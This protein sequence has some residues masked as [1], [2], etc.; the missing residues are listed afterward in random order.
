MAYD[1][2]VRQV[3][4]GNS[5]DSSLQQ[6]CIG[7]SYNSSLQ[8]MRIKDSYDSSLQQIRIKDSYDSSLQQVRIASCFPPS[9]LIQ[10]NVDECVPIGA[11]A[12]GDKICSWNI[13]RKKAEFTTVVEIHRLKA[14]DLNCFN[15]SLIVS[16]SHPLMVLEYDDDCQLNVP[17]WKLALDVNVGDFI[18][19][20][21]GIPIVVKSK[22]Y[23]WVG[24]G[25]EVINLS[26]DTGI[27]FVVA[28]CVVRAQNAADYIE[29]V[30]TKI[31]LAVQFAA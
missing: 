11:I 20:F 25:T 31:P 12:V 18:L 2:S 9:A 7:S 26:T 22:N 28:D 27:P 16:P 3:C 23:R 5:Y 14:F 4:I 10:R 13:E 17:K 19:G 1:S 29:W 15:N 6:V 8:Q 30:K 24:N 21:K